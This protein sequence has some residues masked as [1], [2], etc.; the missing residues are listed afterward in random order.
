MQDKPFNLLREPWIMVLDIGGKTREVSLLEVLERAHEFRGLAGELPTQD[1]AILR[2]L[3]AA[4]YATFTRADVQGSR[5]PIGNASE[6]LERW[7]SLW[8]LKHFPIEPIKTR[9]CHYEER[10]DL[11]HPERPFYQVAFQDLPKDRDG[12]AIGF[13][14]KYAKEMIGDLGESDNKP[15]LFAGRTDK[16]QLLFAEAARWLLHTH[17]FDVAPAGAP[18]KVAPTIKGYGLPWV[19]GLGVIWADGNN[20]FETL[21]LNLVLYDQKK[22]PWQI[23][24][25]NWETN[26]M[27]T[28]DTI[29]DIT[30]HRPSNPAELFTMQFRRIQLQRDESGRYVEGYKLWSGIKPDYNNAFYETMTIWQKDKDKKNWVPRKHTAEKQMWRD[31][32]AILSLRDDSN[33]AGIIIWLNDLKTSGKLQIPMIRLHTAGVEYKNNAALK[34]V[35]SDSLQVNTNILSQIGK[36]WI[37][38]ISNLLQISDK[39]VD[40]LYFLARDLAIASGDRDSSHHKAGEDISNAAK[41]EAYFRLD[42]PFRR[43]LADIDPAQSDMEEAE[44][45]WKNIIKRILL[46]LGEEMTHQSGEKAIIGRWVK[47]KNDS[48]ERLYTAPGAL[49]KFSSN[50]RRTI[51]KGG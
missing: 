14:Q 45:D 28:A 36:E 43:W 46:Q 2:L 40:Q 39:C 42:M 38:R 10:F 4:L 23:C 7:Q 13:T 26:E 1:V 24:N 31:F 15:R 16:D 12:K 35:F 50:I 44:Q 17:A 49:A 6:A 51:G 29:K 3:M 9:L 22:E 37:P 34:H 30:F 5:K 20:L 25:I 33:P 19:S 18:A 11:L 41:A 47:S 27:C 8:D 21:M 32:S 48:K